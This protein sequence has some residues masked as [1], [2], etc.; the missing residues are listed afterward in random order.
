[1]LI[2]E[3]GIRHVSIRGQRRLKYTFATALLLPGILSAQDPALGSWRGYWARGGDTLLVTMELEPGD[4]PNR[5]QAA[6]SS[7]RLRVEG[8]PFTSVE[9]DDCC[10]I[11]LT[12]RGDATTSLF[13]G[14]IRGDSITGTF[15]EA[16]APGTFALR[17]EPV[18]RPAPHS[19]EVAFTNGAVRLSG[20]LILPST[21]PPYPAVVMMHGSGAEGRF[22]NRFLAHRFAEAGVAA[23]IFDKRGVGHSSGDWPSAGFEDLA[24]DGAAGIAML[25]VRKDIR[26]DHIGLFGHSQGGTVLPL[27]AEISGGAAFLIASAASGVAADS[28]ERFSLRNSARLSLLAPADA[29]AA[30]QYVEALVAVAYHG[31]P[32]GRM[33]SLAKTVAGQP[34]YFAPPPPDNFYW[35][36]SRRIAGY[37]APSHWRK[38]RSPVLLVY[39][40]S[41]QRV[42]AD[43]SVTAIRD[44][45]RTARRGP[46][47]V[48]I[49]PGAD[50]TE[51][52]QRAG[53]VW[54]RNAPGYLEDLIA[55]VRQAAGVDPRGAGAQRLTRSCG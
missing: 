3:E 55:W 13:E 27:V 21:A 54:P 48:C 52:V 7:D 36:F 8:I 49:Y 4:G 19:E 39:G 38:V 41:D 6:F 12:L 14:M 20:T 46:P 18:G 11:R 43:A 10:R 15:T 32:R 23:L 37:D 44:A 35:A 9:R 45:L 50:H 30:N 42:P 1:M 28:T 5:L 33:D 26:A 34:W 51:R 16:G 22:A 47:T 29:T 17:R 2:V 31:A 53:D 40:S 24:A 25:R